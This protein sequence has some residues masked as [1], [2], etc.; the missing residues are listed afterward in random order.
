[1]AELLETSV[2]VFEVDW[3][4][5]PIE[6]YLTLDPDAGEADCP[7]G[8]PVGSQE[9]VAVLLGQAGVP[10]DEARSLSPDLWERRWR[11]P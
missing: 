5:S 4:V 8:A 9:D 11:G 1:V 3:Y 10:R 6:T 2:G 7:W